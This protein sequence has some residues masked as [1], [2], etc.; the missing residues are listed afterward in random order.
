M[1]SE[2]SEQNV[3]GSVRLQAVRKVGAID[4]GHHVKAHH[5]LVFPA[6]DALVLS[7]RAVVLV[8]NPVLVSLLVLAGRLEVEPHS[9]RVL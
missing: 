8:V 3:V 1:A 5:V 2:A 9:E 7:L 6:N 4:G